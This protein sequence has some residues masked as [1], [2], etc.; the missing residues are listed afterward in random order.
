MREVGV[1][2]YWPTE[3]AQADMGQVRALFWYQ[4]QTKT[5]GWRFGKH[6]CLPGGPA[7]TSVE[8]LAGH[9]LLEETLSLAFSLFCMRAASGLTWPICGIRQSHCKR[10][11]GECMDRK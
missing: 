2:C 6:V 7:R 4:R 1:A 3:V 9:V 10:L 5:E 8:H 11:T